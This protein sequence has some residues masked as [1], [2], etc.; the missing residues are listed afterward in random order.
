MVER[1]HGTLKAAPPALVPIP[2]AGYTICPLYSLVY[3]LLSVLILTSHRLN[4]STAP[5]FAS[6]AISYYSLIFYQPWFHAVGGPAPIST[7][8]P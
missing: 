5:T 7:S 6:L 3:G 2:I 8:V 4:S 1:F